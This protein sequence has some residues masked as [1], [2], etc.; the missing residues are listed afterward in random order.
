[1]IRL[2]KKNTFIISKTGRINLLLKIN[3]KNKK[4]YKLII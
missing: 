3:L 4:F 2:L 1:M